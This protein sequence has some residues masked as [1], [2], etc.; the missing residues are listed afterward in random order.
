MNPTARIASATAFLTALAAAAAA[1]PQREPDRPNASLYERK[2]RPLLAARCYACHSGRIPNP[3]AGLR[4]DTSEGWLRGGASGPAIV[5]G[6]PEQSRLIAVV[7]HAQGVVAMPPGAKLAPAEIALLEEWIRAGA[8]D[9]KGL[10]PRGVDAGHWSL[11]PLVRPAL[12]PVKD[13]GWCRTSIDRFILARLEANGLKPSPPADP[14][15]LIRRA[16]FDLHGLPPTPEEIDAFLADCAAELKAERTNG[17]MDEWTNGRTADTG[18]RRTRTSR[19]H[20]HTSTR[21]HVHTSTRPLL[22]SP[23][24]AYAR[25]IDRLLSSPRYGERWGRHWL[26][27]VHYGDTHGYDK[28]KRRDNAWPYRDYVIRSLNAD[29]PY[30]RFLREQV[31]GDLL[32][33]DDPDGVVATGFIVAGPWDFVGHVELAEGTAEKAKTRVLD[34]DDMVA[35]TMSTFASMTVHCARCHDHKFDPISQIDYYRLQAAFAGVERGDRPHGGAS[36]GETHAALEAR[37]QQLSALRTELQRRIKSVSSPE[38]D[39]LD[40]AIRSLKAE[41]DALPPLSGVGASPTNG[42]HS[43]VAQAADVEKWVQV[44]LGA[45]LP[46]E[47]VRL[48][49]ARPTDFPDTPGFGFPPRFRVAVADDPGFATGRVVA[50][51]SAADFPNPGDQ[52]VSLALSGVKG[53]YVRVTAAGLWPRTGDYVFALGELEVNSGGG[54]VAAGRAVSALDS[55][56]GG[57]WSA[58]HLVDGFDSR[59]RLADLKK[60]DVAREVERRRA[61]AERHRGHERDRSALAA[62]LIP[63]ALREEL[64]VTE[65]ALAEDRDR[66]RAL[67]RVYAALPIPPRKIHLLARGEVDQPRQELGPG[68]LACVAGLEPDFSRSSLP[69]RAALAGWLAHPGNTLTWRSIV[70]R[71]WHYHFGRGLVDTPNDFGRNGSLP[72][73]PELLDWLAWHFT[74]GS[75]GVMERW[76]DERQRRTETGHHST[77]PLLHHSVSPAARS[78]SLK[79]LHRL[80]MLSST[81]QQSSKL[82][83]PPNPQSSI[84][85]PQSA[86]SDNRL[87]WRM[88][89]QR[90]DAEAIRDTVLAVSEKLDLKMGGPGFELFR[91]KDDHSPVYDHTAVDKINDPASWRRTVYRLTVRSVPNPFLESLDCADPNINTPVRNSTLTALQ[92]LALLNDPFMVDQA[93]HFAGRLRRMTGDPTAQLEAAYS[94]ALGRP[95]RPAERKQLVDYLARHGLPNACRLIFN[96]NEFIFVD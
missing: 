67:P 85:N 94:L 89:R 32:Y 81:Y 4:L 41:L 34:R 13:T 61:L 2:V 12:P 68:A 91:F 93:G 20:I 36:A 96:M 60:P 26:D 7:R 84:L 48:F 10:G 53:R 63:T 35:N 6:S 1:A 74:Q 86:D 11:R 79:S 47:E 77:T 69:P 8:L 43:A 82:S 18:N 25:L 37:Q 59:R 64:A 3:Q 54:N 17:R 50:D 95:P 29:K 92:A 51:H 78:H 71:V 15:T 52:S 14:R 28:D 83:P 73:H 88:N 57:L 87:L 49:P 44:D 80:I 21:P 40:A 22:R 75:D 42:Y 56:E 45:S 76:S 70:N 31:A 27:V 90:L 30:D 5:P 46:V 33:P 9:G 65:A 23:N 72:T 24:P 19:P 16:T 62:A 66:L 58:R 39:R 55:I 38:L